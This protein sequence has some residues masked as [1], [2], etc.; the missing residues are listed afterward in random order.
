M[1]ERRR[2]ILVL[3]LLLPSLSAQAEDWPGW[4]GPNRDDVAAE[5]GLLKS[6]PKNGP[7]LLWTYTNSGVG[8]SGPAIVGERLFLM[9]GRDQTEYVFALD[10]KTN[11]GSTAQEVWSA[12][13]GPL[14]ASKEN[15]YN[16]GPSATP[17][18]DGE[19][20]YALGGQGQLVCVE[21]ATGKERWRKNLPVDMAA[22]VNPV[23]GGPVKLGWGFTWSPLVDGERLICV[24]GG[25]QGTL[26]ALDKKTGQIL[27]RS[28]EL[29]DQATYSSPI[30]IE[31]GGIRQYVQMTNEGVS[32]VAA[33][34]GSLLWRYLKKPPYGDVVIPTPIF[35]DGYIY[36][37]AG[38]G[39]GCDL[40]KL[41]PA[42]KEFKVEKVYANKTMVN[43]QGGVVLVGE[44]LYGYSEGKGWVCQEFKS[45][46]MVWSQKRALGRG[47]LTYADGKL[48]CYGEDEG[49]VALVD[50]TPSGW[51]EH[52]RFEVPQHSQRR[53]SNGKVWTHPVVSQ[54]H[55][56]LR[57]QD[58][59]FC[60]DVKD[61]ASPMPK[62]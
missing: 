51:K 13:I 59:L 3:C 7:P 55:L 31:V 58:L 18:V 44:H 57:D 40:I 8:Y 62:D 47:S 52:G 29:T 41:T 16:A 22:E 30:V 39:A 38:Y 25:P 4:R 56:Y 43:Q 45:G 49:V 24:P 20:L 48:Y 21:T 9:G 19:L 36:V 12:K 6:W 37:S 34:D 60:Y 46:N 5:A 42:G 33:N 23:S 27:W 11:Q 54:A 61:H 2:I 17:T 53:R 32:G 35:H 15:S 1:K 28:K 26:A 50:A 10:L 14:F